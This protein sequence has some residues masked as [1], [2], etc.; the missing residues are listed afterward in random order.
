[1]GA[2]DGG[3]RLAVEEGLKKAATAVAVRFE[4]TG[5]FVE[6]EIASAVFANETRK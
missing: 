4:L 5:V 6:P 1:M 3:Y 2:G